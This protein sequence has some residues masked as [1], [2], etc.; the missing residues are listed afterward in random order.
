MG[1]FNHKVSDLNCLKNKILRSYQLEKKQRQN[2]LLRTFSEL[3]S[4]VQ[5]K[6]TEMKS[7][8]SFICLFIHT[9]RILWAS[10]VFFIMYWMPAAPW[11]P[12]RC[13]QDYLSYTIFRVGRSHHTSLASSWEVPKHHHLCLLWHTS[14]SVC[15]FASFL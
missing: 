5:T 3:N 8:H 1:Q 10:D 6:D 2:V 14:M 4:R 9:F 13:D 11:E 7:T 12:D 15:S